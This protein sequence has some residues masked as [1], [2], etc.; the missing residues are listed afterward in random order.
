MPAVS[1]TSGTLS[2]YSAMIYIGSSYDE[3][4]P[5][6]LLDDVLTGTTPV[7]WIY[8]NIWQLANRSTS[9]VPTYGYN[10]YIFD[11]SSITEVTYKSTQLSRSANNTSGIMS[12][13]ALDTTTATVLASAVHTDGTTIPWALRSH[14]LTYIGE[15]PFDY[16]MDGDR[17]LAFCDL[18]FDLLAPSTPARHRALVRIE[19]VNSTD[20]P[21]DLR[22]VADYLSS[23]NIP[24]SIATIPYYTDPLGA[25]NGGVAQTIPLHAAPTVVSAIQYMISKGGAVHMH[26][27]THQYSNVVN[28]YTGVSA[29]DFE[30]WLSHIDPTTN[31]VLQDGAV[32]EDAAAWTANRITLGLQELTA[33]G[34]PSPFAW[35]FPHYAGSALDS[36]TIHAQFSK[37]YQRSVFFGGALAGG[38]DNLTHEIGLFYP[39]MVHDVYGFDN[40][41][42][43][44]GA[45][46]PT[47]ANNNPAW[48]VSDILTA[49]NRTL[50]VRDGIASFYFHPYYPLT[51]LQQIVEGLLSAG[52]T[53]VAA[54]SL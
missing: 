54:D 53:F 9:F 6:A 39:F 35:E 2:A 45:Y 41:P 52:Y 48:L 7:I 8:D 43:D 34:L 44:V 46:E 28:P 10:P 14:N 51:D 42:E 30:F 19:D 17:Y 26:G 29:D 47:P 49:A 15:L 24:F 36:R 4:L 11:T 50:V 25:Y 21:N 23:L 40:I 33:A 5:T 32:P 13:S 18:L 31:S 38:P 16:I 1:Y 20:D 27:Y 22:S 12:Y 3:P 37:T